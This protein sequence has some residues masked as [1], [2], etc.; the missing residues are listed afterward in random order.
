MNF[1]T[2]HEISQMKRFNTWMGDLWISSWIW[3]TISWTFADAIDTSRNLIDKC[4]KDHNAYI[5]AAT[6][7][8]FVEMLSWSFIKV[9]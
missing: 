8:E 7:S 3:C 1:I 9:F 6:P 5:L 2:D 4:T